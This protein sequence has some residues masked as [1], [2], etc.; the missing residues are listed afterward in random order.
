M[1][2]L[3]EAMVLRQAHPSRTLVLLPYFQLV[4]LARQMWARWVAQPA[5]TAAGAAFVPRFDTT[6]NWARSLAGA[7]PTA[8][9]LT[10]QA[11][12]D[13]PADLNGVETPVGPIQVT[14]RDDQ[15]PVL[16]NGRRIS[17][18]GEMRD[19]PTEAI[20]RVEILPEEVA[21]K[22]GYTADQKVVNIVLRQRFRASTIDASIGG[23]TDGG[24]VSEIA[25]EPEALHAAEMVLNAAPGNL[26]YA[27][28]DLIRGLD[29]TPQ[30]MELE[31][32]EP[33]LFLEHAHD[34]GAAFAAAVMRAIG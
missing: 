33:D 12:R 18:P 29:H 6:A 10:F 25:P 28:V 23:S 7:P 30:L 9:D 1:A 11:A 26:T 24:Q 3:A 34:K 14:W 19:I 17:G 2:R 32:I 27:R 31:V 22:Y 5:A 8:D 16:L 13:L 20:Q 15:G 21:L 4:P